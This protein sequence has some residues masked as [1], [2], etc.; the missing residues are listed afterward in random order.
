MGIEIL[1]LV[2]MTEDP[3]FRRR[4]R[5]WIQVLSAGGKVSVE[6]RPPAW[7]TF[8]VE[9]CEFTNRRGGIRREL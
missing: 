7:Y 3:S 4:L 6:I 5:S 2:F 9:L 1:E 8:P